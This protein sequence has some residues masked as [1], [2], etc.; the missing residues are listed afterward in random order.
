MV[1][2]G[3]AKQVQR[4]RPMASH[5]RA[6]ASDPAIPADT[7]TEHRLFILT[8]L[9]KA[10]LGVIQIATAAALQL[11]AAQTLPPLLRWLVEKELSEDPNDF[12]AAR[13][14]S[15]FS[16]A[17]PADLTF[18]KIYFLSH[19]LLHLIVVAAILR[20]ARWASHAAIAVLAAFVV[21]QM[22]E[23]VAVGGRMLLILSVI[24]LAVIALTLRDE[25]R[26]RQMFRDRTPA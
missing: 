21:Y 18:Y 4:K 8:I 25:Q 9:A 14:L 20:G 12:I 5:E 2:Q 3:R 19:G 26:K 16:T 15:L 6:T 13:L 22:W 23:W 24:D 10:A 7:S 1:Y 17:P 11:G